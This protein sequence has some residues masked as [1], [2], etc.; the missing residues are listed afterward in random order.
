MKV[1]AFDRRSRPEGAV[2]SEWRAAD[3]WALRR[4]DWP[5]PDGAVP[6]GS[7]LFAGGRGDFIE[8]YLEPIAHWHERGWNVVSFDWRGQGHSRGSIVGG[9][10]TDF[11]PLVSDLDAIV[12]EVVE[13]GPGPHVAIGHSMGG[14]LLLRALAERRPPLE[15]AV[16]V[17][18]MLAVNSFPTPAITARWVASIFAAVGGRDVAL[19]P[20]SAGTNSLLLRQ[21]NLTSCQE[22]YADEIWWKN[23]E[24]G[25]HLGAPSWGWLDAAFRSTA[26]HDQEVLKRVTTPVLLVGTERDRL[27]SPKAIRAAATVLPTAELRMFDEAAH[28]LLRETDAV[29]LQTLAWIDDFLDRHAPA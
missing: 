15:A 25:F 4:M 26:R 27:V 14:H 11:D 21:A 13:A 2:F 16:L 6:R 29:R 9:N 5:Q 28:E 1:K 22:R 7:L 18:P 10:F 17:A 24:P 3:G 8:K 19:W 20:E 23:R 12:R